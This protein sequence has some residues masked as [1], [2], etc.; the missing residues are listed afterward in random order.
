M[1]SFVP[2]RRVLPIPLAIPVL[3]LVGKVK[4]STGRGSDQYSAPSSY[5]RNCAGT[6]DQMIIERMGIANEDRSRRTVEDWDYR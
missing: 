6:K 5:G 4:V 1:L 3:V 2:L